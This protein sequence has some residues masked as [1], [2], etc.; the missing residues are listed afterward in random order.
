M[1]STEQQEAVS[2]QRTLVIVVAVLAL[3][4]AGIG[5]ATGGIPI[6]AM[7]IATIQVTIVLY[8]LM[9]LKSE[10]LAMH[11]LTALCAFF[12]VFMLA[13]TIT[14]ATNTINGTEKLDHT[15]PVATEEAH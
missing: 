10:K 12:I 7:I 3:V 14:A 13:A 1:S 4:S 8:F 11:G 5:V 2:S 9:H 6:V 15:K